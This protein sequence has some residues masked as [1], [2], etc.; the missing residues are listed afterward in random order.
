MKNIA[1]IFGVILSCFLLFV[2]SCITSIQINETENELK[3]SIE[4][5]NKR[6]QSKK[7]RLIKK[8]KKIVDFF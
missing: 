6:I 4:S 7:I 1:I 8:N 5:L 2:T 3:S